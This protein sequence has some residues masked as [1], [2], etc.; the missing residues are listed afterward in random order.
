MSPIKVNNSTLKDLDNS[1]MVEISN[2]KL[3][4]MIRLIKLMYKHLNEFKE[5]T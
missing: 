3:K 1:D 4:R 5:N 2:N